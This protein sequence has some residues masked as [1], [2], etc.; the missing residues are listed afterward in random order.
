MINTSE[1]EKVAFN[2]RYGSF[3][4]AVKKLT[5]IK[6]RLQEA[7]SENDDFSISVLKKE[8]DKYQNS[9]LRYKELY[10]KAGWV[11]SDE[12]KDFIPKP[13]KPIITKPKGKN[14]RTQKRHRLVFT[15]YDRLSGTGKTRK[16]KYQQLST[17]K[18]DGKSYTWK[19]IKD[20]IEKKKYLE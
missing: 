8:F 5:N 3:N 7:I 19:Y 6:R 1:Y 14:E 18:F 15:T 4:D 9:L 13:K 2:L 16:E 20:I 12:M 11:L 10:V 17:R